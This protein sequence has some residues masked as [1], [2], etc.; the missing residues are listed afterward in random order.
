MRRALAFLAASAA[1]VLAVPASAAPGDLD[2]SFGNGGI[3]TTRIP[4]TDVASAIARQ[5]D[6][7]LLVGG[8]VD[9]RR[10]DPGQAFAIERYNAD[11][12]LDGAFGSGGLWRLDGSGLLGD[13]EV[14]AVGVQSDGHV[15]AF[16]RE[17]VTSP[18]HP[19]GNVIR[20]AAD[21]STSDETLALP[22]IDNPSELL[23][24]IVQ[25][26]DS[27]VAIG[28]LSNGA[29]TDL[30]IVRFQPNLDPDTSFGTG[31][32]GGFTLVD[33]GSDERGYAVVSTGTKYYACG[34]TGNGS[35]R[36]FLLVRFTSTGQ[37]DT[38]FGTD[39]IVTTAVGSGHAQ[40]SALALA[41][42]G[43]GDILVAGRA[44]NGANTDFAI[45]RYTSTGQLASNFGNGGIVLTDFHAGDDAANDIVAAGTEFVVAGR[46][47]NGANNVMGF[48]RY[49]GN[50]SLD[51][52]FGTMGKL[53]RGIGSDAV[54]TSLV[55]YGSGFAAAGFGTPSFLP[56]FAV[57]RFDSAGGPV[58][59]FGSTGLVTSGFPG[60]GGEARVVGHQSDGRLVVGGR[61][62]VGYGP[63]SGFVLVR[64]DGDGTLDTSFG[65]D[66]F[67]TLD[68]L[69]LGNLKAFAIQSDDRIVAVGDSPGIPGRFAVVRF[70]R[71]GKPDG[72]FGTNGEL[73]S[74][75]GSLADVAG[76]AI[77]DDGA[78]V[79]C[80]TDFSDSTAM[81]ALRLTSDGHVD[82]GYGQGGV[83]SVQAPNGDKTGCSSVQI[84]ARGRAVL[85]GQRLD[86]S[87]WDLAVARLTRTGH[88][89]AAFSSDG[90]ASH[91]FGAN[92]RAHGL[93]L[94]GNGRLDVVGE[95]SDAAGDRSAFLLA[96]WNSD[97]S[98]DTG[99]ATNGR[100]RRH[101]GSDTIDI[102]TAVR[103]QGDGKIVA[104]SSTG[105]LGDFSHVARFTSAGALDAGFGSSGRTKVAQPQD[106][107]GLTLQSDGRI[108]A[109][110]PGTF[111][112][113]T[114]P[115]FPFLA[116]RLL[117]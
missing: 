21:G 4:G 27:I 69:P 45:V 115:V 7:K 108:V 91:G 64:Y 10:Q 24:G 3:A 82:T 117:P 68:D 74:R 31:S 39:G 36:K 28:Y 33:L 101:F 109:V 80:L 56:D 50:G 13:D 5:P 103:I 116:V 94:D 81:S 71:N 26:N 57:L 55:P 38:T 73:V 113:G 78:I 12:T 111:N 1:L 9:G 59:G 86:G 23:G 98:L 95:S 53:E 96:R 60:T 105:S 92:E 29:N 75:I 51:S 77:Q 62:L 19:F 83:G 79:V 34:Y 18:S 43:T 58:G 102:G 6:G 44:S 104:T 41:T 76:V 97:G 14:N 35:S 11:G 54:A 17:H 90:Y 107:V 2:Q 15:I 40:A 88:P 8:H 114:M 48:A 85:A 61:G 99:F 93:A 46:V 89:D 30:G 16:G 72:S 47:R 63:A 106:L 112:D 70:T 49:H 110:G 67:A 22:S 65:S 25:G 20:I 84:D 37:P 52:S 66:G 42:D 32:G 87:D 100:V